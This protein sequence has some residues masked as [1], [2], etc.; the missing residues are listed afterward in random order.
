MQPTSF[1][2]VNIDSVEL[3]WEFP[4]DTVDNQIV[5]YVLA[6]GSDNVRSIFV[7]GSETS[8]VIGDL[9]PGSSYI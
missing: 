6:L 1:D 8:V 3:M 9:L 4:D 5:Q 2:N 7:I